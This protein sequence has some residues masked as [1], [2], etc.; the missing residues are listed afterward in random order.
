MHDRLKR[1]GVLRPPF[2]VGDTQ[3][4]CTQPDEMSPDEIVKIS[5]CQ[6]ECTE[7][8]EMS[9]EKIDT[10]ESR[11]RR[12]P[13][14]QR[15]PDT[16][17]TPGAGLSC[18]ESETIQCG[19]SRR[20]E[21]YIVFALDVD[22]KEMK[23]QIFRFALAETERQQQSTLAHESVMEDDQPSIQP[24]SLSEFFQRRGAC[25]DDHPLPEQG[26]WSQ[27]EVVRSWKRSAHTRA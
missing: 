14:G 21:G 10:R 19:G 17:P 23:K 4:K 27:I 26:V 11:G 7:T 1:G 22:E 24:E 5:S 2:G 3:Q 20:P 16:W 25:I 18:P 8:E 15:V 12:W 13:P 6:R 9:F